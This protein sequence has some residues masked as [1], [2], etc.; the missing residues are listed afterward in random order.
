MPFT[1][2]NFVLGTALSALSVLSHLVQPNECYYY[3]SQFLD[4]KRKAEAFRSHFSD[5]IILDSGY[6]I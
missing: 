6:R 1:K 4:E 2:S 3:Y 5:H